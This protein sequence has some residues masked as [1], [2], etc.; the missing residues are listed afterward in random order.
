MGLAASQA[1]LLVL[2]AR[3]SDLEFRAQN[4]TNRKLLLS[5]QTEQIAMDYS[6][7]LSNKQMRFVFDYDS[8]QMDD[9]NEIFSIDSVYAN[10]SA[11][12]GSYRVRLADGRIAVADKSQ[13]PYAVQQNSNGSYSI[14][15]SKTSPDQ[16]YARLSQ[17]EKVSYL[18]SSFKS[19]KESTN[20]DTLLTT[21][22]GADLAAEM[23]VALN[24]NV[25]KTTGAVVQ[26]RREHLG[27]LLDLMY[28]AA[29]GDALKR[30]DDSGA[31]VAFTDANFTKLNDAAKSTLK[32]TFKA[33]AEILGKTGTDAPTVPSGKSITDLKAAMDEFNK[34][35]E[36][37]T[38]A[39]YVAAINKL[40]AYLLSDTDSTVGS[41]LNNKTTAVALGTT[42]ADTDMTTI[43]DYGNSLAA[44]YKTGA[45]ANT[46]SAESPEFREASA[47]IL[48]FISAQ[49]QVAQYLIMGNAEFQ[50][51]CTQGNNVALSVEQ[52]KGA[53]GQITDQL[54]LFADGEEW[55]VLPALKNVSFF[56]NALRQGSL[57]L[58]KSQCEFG[59][60]ATWSPVTIGASEIVQDRLNT[61]D[62][63]K[64]QAEYDT[65][66][67]IIN[68]QDKQLDI[69]LRQ[70]ET[71]QKACDNE[72]ESV[73]KILDKN[74]E[75]S[76]KV[77]S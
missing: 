33:L 61:E 59:K 56:Q 11:F 62:D 19:M 21:T 27:E 69:E 24:K 29:G 13:L 55:I 76:F 39:E 72:Y 3:K 44:K 54:T 35:S 2:T 70:I 71:Q 75:R 9:L 41:W 63:A 73:K 4:I 23:K 17:A 60:K 8:N 18:A 52:V 57:I 25:H 7:A 5:A 47:A 16:V 77:F 20:L 50:A 15:G 22:Y 12:V 51:R 38:S 53:D 36:E 58:E 6:R 28:T 46:E 26:P 14:T 49:P 48:S 40:N 31:A 42:V 67:A 1:R 66:T 65:K 30:T 37:P 43:L 45:E 34:P 68:T 32:T 74:I 10:N 64:A